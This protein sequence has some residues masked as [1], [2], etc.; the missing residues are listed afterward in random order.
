[1][2][3]TINDLIEKYPNTRHKME[4]KQ[5]KNSIV[6]ILSAIDNFTIIYPLL[7]YIYKQCKKNPNLFEP[8]DA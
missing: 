7:K 1:M 6:Q 3:Q 5:A 4:M 2:S 8:F